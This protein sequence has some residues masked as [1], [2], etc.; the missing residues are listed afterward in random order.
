MIIPCIIYIYIYIFIYL[1]IYIYIYILVHTVSPDQPTKVYEHAHF[2]FFLKLWYGQAIGVAMDHGSENHRFGGVT[3]FEHQMK[4]MKVMF[5]IIIPARMENM[6]V[7]QNGR[8]PFNHGFQYKNTWFFMTCMIWGTPT[9]GNLRISFPKTTKR[10]ELQS[11]RVAILSETADCWHLP[12]TDLKRKG[13]SKKTYKAVQ[14]S[15]SQQKDF[16]F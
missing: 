6:L 4:N 13:G 7:S 9:L 14:E 11:S 12:T 15:Y 2:Y 1:C 5:W 3:D 16:I 8:L 10:K